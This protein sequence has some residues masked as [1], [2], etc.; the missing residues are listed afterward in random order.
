MRV[1]MIA[2]VVLAMP[3]TAVADSTDALIKN[4]D[5]DAKNVRLAAVVAL[6]KQTDARIILPFVKLLGNDGDAQV[7]A[8]AAT[9][10]G[11]AVTST[12]KDSLKGLAIKTL[13][14]A[15]EKDADASVRKQAAAS[16]K[17]ITGATVTPTTPTPATGG[18]GGA[19]GVYVNVGPMSS[20]T[21]TDDPKWRAIMVRST[22]TT[23]T[24][25]APT[26]KQT[27]PGGAVPSKAVLDKAGASGFYVDGTLNELSTKGIV[28]SCKV[29]MLLASFPEK[30]VF[31]FLNGAAS[32]Q[33]SDSESEKALARQDC[34]DAVITDLITKKIIPTIKSKTP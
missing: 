30:S 2:L 22:Q 8:V 12:T 18:G 25:T 1:V 15:S 14:S 33:A 34:V 3:A 27:W 24:R 31:G 26:M 13:T 23:L 7:R 10:L 32:V 19:G 4:L 28:V 20:K 11:N 29:S 21:G 6:A 17:R 9:G 5:S 16:L